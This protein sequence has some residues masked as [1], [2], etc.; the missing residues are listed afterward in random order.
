MELLT[1]LSLTNEMPCAC[2]LWLLLFFALA[3]FSLSKK[4]L[5]ETYMNQMAISENQLIVCILN[6]RFVWINVL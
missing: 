4:K 6:F 2:S 5:A 3:R 1:N